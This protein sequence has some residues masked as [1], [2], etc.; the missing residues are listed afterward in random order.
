MVERLKQQ[1]GESE[2]NKLLSK[3]VYLFNIGGNDY[4]SLFEGNVDELPLSTYKKRAYMDLILGNLTTHLYV[5]ITEPYFNFS[6]FSYL[7]TL[8]M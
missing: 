8:Q 3:A 7:L 4:F 5:R 6:I 1:V 2:A